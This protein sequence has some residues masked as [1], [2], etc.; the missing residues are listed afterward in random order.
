MPAQQGPAVSWRKE[1]GAAARDPRRRPAGSPVFGAST[2]LICPIV[3]D[4]F[5]PKEKYF[6]IS[7]Q[8]L[9]H[10]LTYS[11]TNCHLQCSRRGPKEP[12]PQQPGD[13]LKGSLHQHSNHCH[14]DRV[15]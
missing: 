2:N 4:N 9:I 12:P 14:L 6:L 11:L 13:L 10:A 7:F 3:L 1:P 8:L 15:L 5:F